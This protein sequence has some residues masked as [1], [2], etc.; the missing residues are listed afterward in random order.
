MRPAIHRAASGVASLLVLVA[1]L[2]LAHFPAQ[3]A[4]QKDAPP[5]TKVKAS[6]NNDEGLYSISFDTLLY[7]EVVAHLPDDM[8][9]GDAISGTV[10]ATPTG[11]TPEEKNNNRAALNGYVVE[12][13]KSKNSGGRKEALS[14]TP[15]SVGNKIK[16]TAPA[17]AADKKE[18]PGELD[19][20]LKTRD[21]RELS[22]VAVPLQS[23]PT[24]D[25]R[26]ATPAPGDFQLPDI[27]QDGAVARIDGFF[28]GDASNT[29]LYIGDEQVELL[30]ESPRRLLFRVPINVIGATRIALKE[31]AVEV[32]GT[33][34]VIAVAL[35]VGK[36]ALSKG[37]T[38]TLTTAVTGMEG[39]QNDAL[40]LLQVSGV[41][42]MSGGNTQVIP[43][44]APDVLPGGRFLLTRTLTASTAGAFGAS[45]I[46]I[47]KPFN[48]CLQD[49][50]S[51]DALLLNTNTGNYSFTQTGGAQGKGTGEVTKKGCERTLTHNAPDRKITA[52]IDT[53]RKTGQAS[54]QVSAP[55]TRFDITDKNTGNNN[56]AAAK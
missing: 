43:I 1:C 7:G 6:L 35:S 47:T 36:M 2:S 42:Q 52:V 19:V 38:T 53:C 12:L 46:I 28:D 17:A 24:D 13:Q 30:A 37:E 5:P 34:R 14:S 31:G 10:V 39:L 23:A 3:T 56:C 40:L 45:G 51:G 16:F 27:G 32:A 29:L 25:A 48:L 22:R 55:K 8:A 33:F 18:K 21:G 44:R 9:A 20:V 41:V 54:L 15:L 49:D 11:G 4:T 26:P 50:K